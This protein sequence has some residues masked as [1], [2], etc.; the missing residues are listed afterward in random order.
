MCTCFALFKA[1]EFRWNR[2]RCQSVGENGVVFFREKMLSQ[3]PEQP[4][5]SGTAVWHCTALVP[6]PHSAVHAGSECC[7]EWFYWLAEMVPSPPVL[8]TSEG[9]E[10]KEADPPAAC[11]FKRYFTLYYFCQVIFTYHLS[12]RFSIYL[13]HNHSYYQAQLS[14]AST[15]LCLSLLW[16]YF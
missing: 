1:L 12:G 10:G 14:P 6:S 13:A 4:G 5:F 3:F 9:R 11:C 2:C 7:M 15:Y 8:S 16:K